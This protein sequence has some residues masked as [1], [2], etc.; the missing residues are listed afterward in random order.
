M[1]DGT[2][3]IMG[4]LGLAAK[5]GRAVIG[6]SLLCTALQRGAEGKTPLVLLLAAD[7]S[8]NTKKRISDRGAFYSV[9]VITLAADCAMLAHSIG[10]REALVAAVGVTERNL[11]AAILAASKEAL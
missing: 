2:A 11:A 9:P 1:C 5:A 4:L 3:K 6:T 8:P 10:K 7:A